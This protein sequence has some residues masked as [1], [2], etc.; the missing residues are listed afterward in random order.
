M[1]RNLMV[2]AGA[3]VAALGAAFA[4]G[5]FSSGEADA[6]AGLSA[7]DAPVVTVYKSPT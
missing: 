4:F 6:A 5:L 1:N 7:T 3:G 2:A